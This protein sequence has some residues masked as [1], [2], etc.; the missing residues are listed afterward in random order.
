MSQR[1]VAVV[2]GIVAVVGVLAAVAVR[3]Y[4][5]WNGDRSV[6]SRLQAAVA[7]PGHRA[8]DLG[9]VTR[10][11]WDRVYVFGAYVTADSIRLEL[12]FDW[13]KAGVAPQS[14][15]GENLLVF[16]KDHK[17]AAFVKNFTGADLECVG[18]P[19]GRPRADARFRVLTHRYEGGADYRALVPVD[20]A[21]GRRCVRRLGLDFE[22]PRSFR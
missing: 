9:S 4:L 3:A 1:R 6:R 17:V 20:A 12:G 16:V 19:G 13:D 18:Q 2:V 22:V 14:Q 10:I 11:A 7:E 21:Q 15:D 8:F 5:G